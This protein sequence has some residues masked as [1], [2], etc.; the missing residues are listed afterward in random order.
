MKDCHP[1]QEQVKYEFL[2]DLYRS[3]GRDRKDHLLRGT[4]TGLYQAW[5]AVNAQTASLNEE[6]A[7]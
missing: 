4:Y 6:P 2:E 5:A 3:A 1:S 7:L